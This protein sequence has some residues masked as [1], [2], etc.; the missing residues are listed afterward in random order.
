VKRIHNLKKNNHSFPIFFVDPDHNENN[1]QIY[2]IKSL[3]NAKIV[4]EKPNKTTRGPPQ[5]FTVKTL[6]TRL[7]ITV[8]HLAALNVVR[9]IVKVAVLRIVPVQSNAFIAPGITRP[10]SGAERLSRK[11][12]IKK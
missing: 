2:N 4:I 10:I 3:F 8:T 11:L 7:N 1:N 9:L 5:C 6:V 12:I